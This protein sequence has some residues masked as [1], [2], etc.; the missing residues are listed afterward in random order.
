[1]PDIVA[2]R[3]SNYELFYDLV[4]VF[5]TSR[6][7]T[8]LH[9][10]HLTFGIFL[11]FIITSIL[12][13]FI[14]LGQTFY[15]NK[16]GERDRLDIYTNIVAMFSIGNFALNI[17]KL[18][19]SSTDVLVYN[20]LLILSYALIVYQYYM[21][22]KQNGFTQDIRVN[23]LTFLGS[24][25]GFALLTGVWFIL[26]N[27][28]DARLIY[29]IGQY[30]YA[31]WLLPI[32][33]PFFFYKYFDETL[34]NFPHL[35][36]R[37]QLITIISFGETVLGIIQTYPLT[38]YPIVGFAFF[39]GMSM[40]FITYILQTHLN[41]NHHQVTRARGLV[42]SHILL[43]IGVNLMTVSIEFF[44]NPHHVE[45]GIILFLTALS[46]YYIGLI[47]TSI[48]NH[49]TY[50]IRQ[51]SLFEYIVWLLIFGII[52]YIVHHNLIYLSLTY[53]IF[54]YSM[55]RVGSSQRRRSREIAN[56]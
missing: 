50:L 46:I 49:K 28:A 11:N 16:Y 44:A 4:F 9:Q 39:I 2:K 22:G 31:V 19:Y 20:G 6:L 23:I 8:L 18:D 36:E 34:I 30:F 52:F 51:H 5:A 54:G 10:E 55:V 12:V 38:D 33:F 14:W 7:T 32:V 1:M 37:C 48:Y 26:K 17:G 13:F 53:A 15:L 47:S 25:I 3:V 27:I 29:F 35:V 21:R 24:M 45:T 42:A 43:I 56:H 41:I 40:M